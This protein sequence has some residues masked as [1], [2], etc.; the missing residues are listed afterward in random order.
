MLLGVFA[1]IVVICLTGFASAAIAGHHLVAVAAEQLSGQQIF[2]LA[3]ASGRGIFVFVQNALY[4]FKNF[5]A[6]NTGHTTRRFFTLVEVSTDV[7]F[8]A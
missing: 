2:F 4:P 1:G 8:V 6:D 3:S 7:A 5:V